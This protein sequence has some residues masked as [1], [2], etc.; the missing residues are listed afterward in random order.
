MTESPSPRKIRVLFVC[1][2]NLC[3][4]PAAE[5]ILK[6]R[7]AEM[8]LEESVDVDSAGTSIY[9]RGQ[10]PD[11]RMRIAAGKRGYQL[12][13]RSKPLERQDV[14][15]SDLIIVMDRE[16]YRQVLCMATDAPDNLHYLSEFLEAGRPRDVPDPYYGGEEGFESVLDVLEEAIPKILHAI[17]SKRV[18]E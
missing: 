12:N 11:S 15:S 1:H 13:S 14:D 2:G 7:L 18:V 10:P 9:H 16:N 6:Q 8:G 4:S 5:A 3:R 17:Q